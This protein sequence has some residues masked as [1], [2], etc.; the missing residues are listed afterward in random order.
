MRTFFASLIVLTAFL[1]CTSRPDAMKEGGEYHSAEAKKTLISTLDAWN[2]GRA[3]S[4]P[5]QTP[6]I[7]FAD[8]DVSAGLLLMDFQLTSPDSPIRKNDVVSVELKLKNRK[9]QIVERKVGYQ[10]ILS[11]SLAVIRSES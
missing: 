7:R 6:P 9:G 1:G 5:R 10:V 2:A 11:P 4:L 8:D 3:G